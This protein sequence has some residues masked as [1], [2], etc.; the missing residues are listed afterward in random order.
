M[1][2]LTTDSNTVGTVVQGGVTSVMVL[3]FNRAL[4]LMLPFL[5]LTLILIIVDLYFG[6]EASNIRY[7]KSHREEDKVKPSKALRRTINKAFEYICW[8]ILSAS[9]TITFNAEWI[10]IVVMALVVGNELLSVVDN[11]LFTRGKKIR[12]LWDVLMKIIGRK[13]DAD[14][15]DVKIE[16]IDGKV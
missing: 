14:L 1:A 16:D 5:V 8:V 12:G 7:K 11:Y 2:P 13:I 4:N 3:Y 15:S 6:I 9:L 10:N